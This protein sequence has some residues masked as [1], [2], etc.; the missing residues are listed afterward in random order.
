MPSPDM[1]ELEFPSIN[2]SKQ[3]LDFLNKTLEWKAKLNFNQR[4][5]G[6]NTYSA[7]KTV[8]N[9]LTNELK[10][11]KV[12]I[13][14]QTLTDLETTYNSIK[15]LSGKMLAGG[16]TFEERELRVKSA[17][18]Q[19]GY[20]DLDSEAVNLFSVIFLKKAALSQSSVFANALYARTV[21]KISEVLE[22]REEGNLGKAA[23]KISSG[24]TPR[25]YGQLKAV[26]KDRIDQN[27][28]VLNT[29]LD[30]LRAIQEISKN[31][32]NPGFGANLFG[33][34]RPKALEKVYGD[35]NKLVND[36]LPPLEQSKVSSENSSGN[37]FK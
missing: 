17:N 31:A 32:L 4:E 13:N 6:L 34:S 27:G 26:I 12:G 9:A 1:Q 23:I 20:D 33:L 28:K 5:N 10:M 24:D 19:G 37:E 14:Q 8:C 18:S 22:L 29:P 16:Q 25:Y 11:V 21:Q 15:F 2:V 36:I 35:V 7:Y 3:D 30:Q